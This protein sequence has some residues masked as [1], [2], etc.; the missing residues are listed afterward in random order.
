MK[1]R[2][3]VMYVEISCF[4]ACLA[5]WILICSTLATEYWSYSEV[6]G[7]VLTTSNFYSNLWMDCVSDSSGV[8]DCKYYPSMLGLS[9]FLH[10]CRALSVIS[11]ILGFWATVLTLIG[12]KCTKI[13]GSVQTNA[14]IA[15]AASMTFLASGLSGLI[16]YSWWG[17]RV[18]KEFLDP[19]YNAQKFEIGAAVFIGW[20][21]SC[22]MITSASV[23]AFFT[24]REA[25]FS[26]RAK[27][28][29]RG[30]SSYATTRTRRTYMLPGSSK[31]ISGPT[32]FTGKLP[33]I[34]MSRVLQGTRAVRPASRISMTPGS[35]AQTS[36]DSF[37]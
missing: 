27:K 29:Q 11:V 17:D 3:M 16:V 23:M 19:N 1:Q 8:S 12:M 14:T 30:P 33:A 35:L 9:V 25:V 6:G 5:G 24:G 37:V 2:T 28:T 20:G 34:S 22:L 10:V 13:G 32:L 31:Q 36:M 18:R 15:F 26:T 21:G 7:I 4:V